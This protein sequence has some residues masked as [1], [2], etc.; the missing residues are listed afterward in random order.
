MGQ[1]DWRATLDGYFPEPLRALA[2]SLSKQDAGRMTELRIRAEQPVCFLAG[3]ERLPIETWIPS[4]NEVR[5][6]VQALLGQSVYARAEE[7]RGGYVTLPGGCR[8]GL[9]GRIVT[10]N[11]RIHHLQ[12]IASVALRLARQVPGAADA[13]M[14]HM[15]EEG[16]PL[17]TL[18]FS[19]PGCGKTTMLRDV[20][21]QLAQGGFQ[22][23]IVD[24]RSELAACVE[25]IPQLDVGPSTDVLDACPKAEG[26]ILMLR[27]FSPQVIITDEIGRAADAEAIE[28]ASR[29]GCAVIAS[30]HAGS[31]EELMR[32]SA[33]GTLLKQQAFRRYIQLGPRAKVEKVWNETFGIAYQAP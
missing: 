30:A 17:S 28:E 11:G 5:Q 1:T 19:T 32:R 14:L 29:C 3:R 12:D 15:L 18:F 16:R 24:E 13:A 33:T 4:G 23:G 6:F 21:R 22:V 2:Q 31:L 7:L 25:G 20:A 8:A 27:V 26:M 10:E 9:C